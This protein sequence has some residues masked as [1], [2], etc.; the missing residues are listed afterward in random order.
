LQFIWKSGK[1]INV[2][3]QNIV[4]V[5]FRGCGKSFFGKALAEV[6]ELPFADLDAEVEFLLGESIFDFVE[7][8]GW[9]VFREVEQ[10]VV[11]DFSRNFSGVIATGGGTIENSKNLQNLK[12]NGG[13]VFINPDFDDVKKHLIATQDDR[14]RPR[15]NPDL[16]LEQEIDQMWNQRKTIYGATADVEANPEY[17]G[18]KMVEAKKIAALLPDSMVPTKPKPRQV[19]ILSSSAGSTMKGLFEAQEK[20]RLPNVEFSLF[21]TN[22]PDAESLKKAKAFGI[23]EIQVFEPEEGMDREEYDR[24]LIN[25]LRA[26]NPDATLLAGWMKILSPLFC[27]Q[28]GSTTYNVHPSLLPE[29]GGMM[30]DDI[31]EAV[32]QN[33]DKYTGCTIHRVTSKVD[34]GETVIQRKVVVRQDDTVESLKQRVQKQEILGFCELLERK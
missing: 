18:D 16:T 15:L 33:G 8:Y 5:G 11:H 30:S 12:K 6:L 4:L 10:R 34:E 22:K 29:Y 17:N 27:D 3:K 28:F 32:L 7:K 2:K 19:A 1:Y 9:Q 13:F 31:H 25:M 14:T 26:V 23:K 24:E 20:G 21:I